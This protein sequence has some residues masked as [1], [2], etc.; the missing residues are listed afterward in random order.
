MQ[1]I[2]AKKSVEISENF[3]VFI[4]ATA[5][6]EYKKIDFSKFTIPIIDTRN[7]I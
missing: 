6:D 4:I 5:H 1:F 7:V 3:D 2:Q